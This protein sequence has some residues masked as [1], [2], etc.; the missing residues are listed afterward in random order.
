MSG[1]RR[2][3]SRILG[4]SS[5][6]KLQHRISW[7]KA[8]GTSNPSTAPSWPRKSWGSTRRPC[9]NQSKKSSTTGSSPKSTSRRD[10]QSCFCTGWLLWPPF[11]WIKGL[12]S[13]APTSSQNVSFPLQSHRRRTTLNPQG[14]FEQRILL[15]CKFHWRRV[16]ARVPAAFYRQPKTIF[17]AECAILREEPAE[18][19][20]RAIIEGRLPY[21]RWWLGR[22]WVKMLGGYQYRMEVSDQEEH[23]HHR[24]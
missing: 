21:S 24:Q 15:G 11:F 18:G 12:T 1:R 14:L 9:S 16:P 8:I 22:R 20:C 19:D 10:K 7:F 4:I 3:A 23:Q 5:P 13:S 2:G 17:P 6:G